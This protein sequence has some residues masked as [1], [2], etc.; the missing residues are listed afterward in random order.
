MLSINVLAQASFNPTSSF[1][2]AAR[3]STTAPSASDTTRSAALMVEV[4]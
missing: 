1:A 2:T 4:S 3:T